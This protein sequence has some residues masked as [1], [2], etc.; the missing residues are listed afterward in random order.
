MLSV[1][2]SV[3]RAD[4]SDHFMIQL[5]LNIDTPAYT[6]NKRIFSLANRVKF[7]IK[8]RSA[9]SNPLYDILN[10]DKA[11]NYFLKKIKRMHYKSF[12][13]KSIKVRHKK[14]P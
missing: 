9:N 10:T 3:I 13:Y 14:N 2:S 6:M 12:P 1:H 7:S 11:F 4:L 8:L 5:K